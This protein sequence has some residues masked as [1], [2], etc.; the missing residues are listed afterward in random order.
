MLSRPVGWRGILTIIGAFWHTLQ[1][2]NDRKIGAGGIKKTYTNIHYKYVAKKV[3]KE[4]C[5]TD[6]KF[7]KFHPLK[8]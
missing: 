3:K 5:I 7:K 2:N 4:A 1:K 8:E 6:E